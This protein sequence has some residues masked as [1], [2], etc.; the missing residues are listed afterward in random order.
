MSALA[1]VAVL[2]A[3]A[4]PNLAF[5]ASCDVP[6]KKV[7]VTKGPGV[8]GVLK[9]L[10]ACDKGTAEGNFETLMKQ[11]GDTETLT[12]LAL[13]AIDNKS[14]KPVWDMME[15]IP[16]YSARKLVAKDV[17]AACGEHADL[18][19]FL[20]GAY[21]ALRDVQ[22]MQWKPALSACTA[23][24]VQ[25]WIE[26][27]AK[28]PPTSTFDD[29]YSAILTVYVDQKK[30]DALP[31]LETAAA[32]AA[33]N[34]GPLGEILDKMDS[35][36]EPEMGEE[37]KPENK[38]AL[39]DALIRVAGGAPPEKAKEIADRLFNAGAT[40]AAAT[41]L[42]KIYPDRVV[43][44]R[45]SYGFAALEI[46]DKEMVLHYAIATDPAKRWSVQG[47]VEP[48]ARAFKPKLK[49]TPTEPWTVAITPEP[50]ANAAALEPWAAEIAAGYTKKGLT[51]KN[52]KEKDA[53]LP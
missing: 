12:A 37:M 46:C 1:R 50:L 26:A 32:T 42:P 44:G 29:K 36:V 14:F 49:C 23:P 20:Q 53:A 31:V 40:D 13:T 43:G 45:L 35:A 52:Q 39:T 16:D 21:F 18:Q 4:A 7:P 3:L 47:D 30:L 33:K 2:F 24:P 38:Q 48:L 34:G 6:L 5:A 9:E 10:Y 8:V 41:L 17:G 51:V 27:T 19:P 11:S 25:A 28:A 22:F 15:K